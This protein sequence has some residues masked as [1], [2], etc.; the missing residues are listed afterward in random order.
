MCI[1]SSTLISTSDVKIKNLF[2]LDLKKLFFITD[3]NIFIWHIKHIFYAIEIRQMNTLK[4]VIHNR[5]PLMK[6]KF[7]LYVVV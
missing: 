3:F 5:N 2:I 4:F 1:C 7:D 6:T